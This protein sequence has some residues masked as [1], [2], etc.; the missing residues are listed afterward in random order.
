MLQFRKQ[1]LLNEI[2]KVKLPAALS[3]RYVKMLLEMQV[4]LNIEYLDLKNVI[5][6][7]GSW[8]VS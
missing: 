3:V 7:G 6:V 5:C 1:D 8:M 4:K 2:V